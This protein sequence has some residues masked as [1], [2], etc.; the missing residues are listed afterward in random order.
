MDNEQ[1]A[2][3][4]DEQDVWRRINH[5]ITSLEKWQQSV[6]D[7]EF[8][9]VAYGEQIVDAHNHTIWQQHAIE[10]KNLWQTRDTDIAANSTL[11]IRMLQ[12]EQHLDAI[13]EQIASIDDIVTQTKMLTALAW[14]LLV[15]DQSI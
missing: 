9:R 14:E 1:A 7:K 3:L 4:R 10:I 8:K 2:L 5:R 13:D 12:V 11:F 15:N 6:F